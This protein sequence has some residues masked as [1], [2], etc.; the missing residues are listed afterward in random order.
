MTRHGYPSD[1]NIYIAVLYA[2]KDLAFWEGLERHLAALVTRFR[3]V[4]I[5]SVQDIEL[6]NDI[7]NSIRDELRR[8]DITLLL[9]SVDFINDD[10]LNKLL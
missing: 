7:N 6:G 10:V 1:S 9:L 4:R 5:W 2:Q 3:N 8:A